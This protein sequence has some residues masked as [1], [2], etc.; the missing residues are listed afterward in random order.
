MMFNNKLTRSGWGRILLLLLVFGSGYLSLW[1]G[2]VHAQAPPDYHVD[3][4][5]G[6]DSN[7]GASW[8]DAFQTLQKAL[9]TANPGEIIWVATGVYYPDELDGSDSNSPTETFALVNGVEIYGGFQNGDTFAARDPVG[10]PTILS[11]DID[12][13]DITVANVVVDTNLINGTNAYNVVS[14]TGATET[15]V[16]DGFTITAGNANST[17]ITCPGKCGGGMYNT[18]SSL[19]LRNVT[20]SGNR[21]DIDGGGMANESSNPTLSDVTFSHNSAGDDG[22]G[23][24]N[25]NGSNPSLID[26]DFISNTTTGGPGSYGGGMYNS[27]D[28]NPTLQNVA[29][30]S[31]FANNSGG[32]MTNNIESSPT[33]TNVTFTSNQA[34]IDGG[35]I[36]NLRG[37]SPALNTVTF[38]DNTAGDDG[39]GMYNSASS[40]PTLINT[41][42]MGNTTTGGSGAYGGGIYNSIDS[43]PTLQNVTFTSNSASDSGGGIANRDNSNPM[44][45]TVT[46][47]SNAADDDGG[48]MANIDNSN[49]TLSDVTFIRN[50]AVDDGGAIYNDDFSSPMLTNTN[51]FTN[52]TTGGSGSN[53]GGLYNNE[54]SSPILTDVIFGGNSASDSGGGMT[55]HDN[56]NPIL[57]DVTFTRNSASNDGGGMANFEISHPTLQDVNFTDNSVSSDGGG[58]YNTENSSPIL[59]SVS[60]TNN[61]ALNDDGGGLYNEIGSSPTLTDVI[62]SNN[63]ARDNGGGMYNT[64]NSTPILTNVTF[65][66]NAADNGGGGMYNNFSSPIISG[67]LFI[68][69]TATA[70]GGLYNRAS[71]PNVI[72]TV[73]GGNMANDGGGLYN[74]EGSRPKL[75]NVVLGN[76]TATSNGGGLYNLEDSHPALTNVTIGYNTAGNTGGGITNVDNSNPTLINVI[77]GSNTAGNSP[78]ISNTNS[79]PEISF[80]LVEGSGGNNNWDSSLGNNGGN[81]LDADPLFLATDNLRLQSTSV[82]IDAGFNTAVTIATD[83]DGKARIQGLAVDMGAYEGSTTRAFDMAIHKTASP[84]PI[85]AGGTLIYTLVISN[86]SIGTA[87]IVT[88]TDTLPTE[89]SNITVISDAVSVIDM[90]ATPPTYS[91]RIAAIAANS[92]AVITISGQIDPA[93]IGTLDNT[94]TVEGPFTATNPDPDTSNNTSSITVSVVPPAPDLT[95]SKTAAPAIITPGETVTYTIIFTNQGVTL[96]N[97]ITITDTVPVAL[98]NIAVDSSGVS[99]TQVGTNPYVWTASNLAVGASGIITLTGEVNDTFEGTLTNTAAI[100]NSNDSDPTNNTASALVTTSQALTVTPSVFT[101]TTIVGRL[102]PSGQVFTITSTSSLSWTVGTTA[103]WLTFSATEGTTPA[104]VTATVTLDELL[105]GTYIAPITVTAPGTTQPITA[106]LIIERAR[107]YLPIIRREDSN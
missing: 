91:W 84:S 40:N 18:N 72:N 64:V 48:A 52:S 4:T 21:A 6:N 38:T 34:G 23:M 26:T 56:S 93:F 20:F 96:A 58:M 9:N 27:T 106:T 78:N 97:S 14:S 24:H 46:F 5:T 10:K 100:T 89:L 19:T 88:V 41:D 30:T 95:I 79:T 28:S 104:I 101:Y 81:N 50:T 63:S 74:L 92:Q 33:L 75:L 80:S 13:N 59:V 15:T 51:F 70:G 86:Q 99:L 60:F 68:S 73:F 3:A 45:Q 87:P 94:A 17:L 67:T 105:I 103:T 8:G 32:G 36:A 66:S 39:G 69:N 57:T 49:P 42:F 31:N 102:A 82:A 77:V 11:G 71:N 65:S 85:I 107:G 76:N 53:G 12:Q 7:A 2:E 37:S 43:N 1:G 61:I 44:L 25:N 35:G 47:T 22:G 83:L 29:F 62:F 54:N 55:N 16:L 98:S 90:G